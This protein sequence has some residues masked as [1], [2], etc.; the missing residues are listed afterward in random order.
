MKVV[1]TKIVPYDD[2]PTDKMHFHVLFVEDRVKYHRT[3]E[4]VVFLDK[5]DVRPLPVLKMEAVR[6]AREFLAE[7]A[8]EEAVPTAVAPE[9]FL[10][11][12][13]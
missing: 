6:L 9:D 12:R 13:Q 11:S 4:V 10:Q 7:A 2:M 8:A 3:C 1:V 5:N